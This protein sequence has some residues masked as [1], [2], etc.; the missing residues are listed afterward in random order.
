MPAQAATSLLY[1]HAGIT[2]A[3]DMKL[4]TLYAI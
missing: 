1:T 4:Q 3:T 2:H